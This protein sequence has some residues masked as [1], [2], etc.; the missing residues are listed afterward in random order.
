[1]PLHIKDEAAT[2]A[3]RELA[4]IRGVSLTDAV[5]AACEEALARDTR[6]RSIP[7]RLADVHARVRSA[8]PTGLKANKAFFD[9]Q[10]GEKK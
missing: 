2:T 10:W 1:M 8:P 5:K 3:V 6:S 7:E 9:A 4:R